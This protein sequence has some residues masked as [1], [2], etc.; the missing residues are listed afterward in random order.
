MLYRLLYS[1]LY[2][3]KGI[4]ENGLFLEERKLNLMQDMVS[5]HLEVYNGFSCV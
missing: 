1:R 5:L 3:I 2:M 4:V